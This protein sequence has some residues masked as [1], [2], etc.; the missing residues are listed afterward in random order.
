MKETVIVVEIDG[1]GRISADAEGFEGDACVAELGRLLAGLGFEEAAVER[2][3]D[4]A[5]RR[6]RTRRRTTL[7][8]KR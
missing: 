8:R 6:A 3:P 7:G 1:D 5:G 2:K 4:A